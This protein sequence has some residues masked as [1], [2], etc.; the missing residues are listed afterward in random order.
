MSQRFIPV[1]EIDLA[2]QSR[3]KAGLIL[4]LDYRD[5]LRAF[6]GQQ[7]DGRRAFP[8]QDA[9]IIGHRAC[10]ANDPT[11]AFI[12][13]EGFHRSANGSDGYLSRQSK[14]VPQCSLTASL[15]RLLREDVVSKPDLWRIGRSGIEGTRGAK[16]G[17]MLLRSRDEFEKISFVPVSAWQNC[18]VVKK[19]L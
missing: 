10:L 14:A 11:L 6:Q 19:R 9:L 2:L 12:T 5:H 4:T 16:Q 8:A 13:L 1:Y 3:Q 7:A 18:S 17:R 15:D